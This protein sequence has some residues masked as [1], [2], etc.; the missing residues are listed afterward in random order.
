SPD[1]KVVYAWDCPFT[2]GWSTETGREIPGIANRFR[3]I[4]MHALAPDGRSMIA[5]DLRRD[6]PSLPV[7]S[8]GSPVP[9]FALYEVSAGKERLRFKDIPPDCNTV[10]CFVFS[11]DGRF[12]GVGGL[13]EPQQIYRWDTRTGKR[14]AVLVSR[15]ISRGSTGQAPRR[16]SVL[17]IGYW[18]SVIN[19]PRQ[20]RWSQHCKIAHA[21]YL[22][23]G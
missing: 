1:S 5:S 22:R 15:A 6:A 14:L 19:P 20:A 18:P 8:E 11:P 23:A 7:K 4:R 13:G 21:I 16:P 12:V 3:E 2:R 10:V 17:R 9:P